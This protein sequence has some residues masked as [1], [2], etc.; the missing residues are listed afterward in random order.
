MPL[1]GTHL[2]R[3]HAPGQPCPRASGFPLC[4][5]YQRGAVAT[6]PHKR[7]FPT[8]GDFGR[9]LA[10]KSDLG[11]PSSAAELQYCLFPTKTCKSCSGIVS[12]FESK[13]QTSRKIASRI[14]S[15][16]HITAMAMFPL[17]IFFSLLPRTQKR[18]VLDPSTSLLRVLGLPVPHARYLQATQP[19]CTNP[20][21][22]A[23]SLLNKSAHAAE[24]RKKTHTR[25]AQEPTRMASECG[26]SMPCQHRD[27]GQNRKL[28]ER[29]GMM[30]LT[31]P[32]P[33]PHLPSTTKLEL[34][35]DVRVTIGHTSKAPDRTI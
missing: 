11:Q 18:S 25:L 2:P 8:Q 7:T 27:G 19:L 12:N 5:A 23:D 1:A 13:T 16:S 24:T 34:V 14:K 22:R 30:T 28:R 33:Q 17:L 4:P 35:M 6:F 21:I 20:D 10:S 31:A 15:A 3:K 9:F 29:A 32:N 26:I